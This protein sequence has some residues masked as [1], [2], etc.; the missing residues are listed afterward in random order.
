MYHRSLNARGHRNR[1]RPYNPP[2]NPAFPRVDGFFH[3]ITNKMNRD[4]VPNARTMWE[5][6]LDFLRTM[7]N[8]IML[9]SFA[10]KKE[11]WHP[12]RMQRVGAAWLTITSENNEGACFDVIAAKEIIRSIFGE[13]L[14][15]FQETPEGDNLFPLSTN[16]RQNNSIFTY[17]L[18]HFSNSLDDEAIPKSEKLKL[19]GRIVRLFEEQ[20]AEVF[21]WDVESTQEASTKLTNE[22]AL[23]TLDAIIPFEI[24]W[25]ANIHDLISLLDLHKICLPLINSDYPLP[26]N[27]SVF[28]D[29]DVDHQE[30]NIVLENIESF[31]KSPMIKPIEKVLKWKEYL[32]IIDGTV[33]IIQN[34]SPK[35][36][37]KAL[38]EAKT[39]LADMAWSALTDIGSFEPDIFFYTKEAKKAF[40]ELAEGNG[41]FW[42]LK[43]SL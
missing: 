36:R 20:T 11:L 39:I 33:A 29:E 19:W 21:Y 22:L 13:M 1:F 30:I 43:Q 18:Y 15:A 24:G 6:D 26:T 35:K 14:A 3:K 23:R 40:L 17:C 16:Y 31:I 4:E 38:D 28:E 34:W 37:F 32:H 8:Q 25:N 7:K 12:S 5:K 2:I 41:N 42:A 10:E 9:W 27:Q